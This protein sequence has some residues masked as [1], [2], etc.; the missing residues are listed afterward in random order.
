MFMVRKIIDC[1]L[2]LANYYWLRI[3][4]TIQ[5]VG[6]LPEPQPLHTRMFSRRFIESLVTV[7]Y[8]KVM[9]LGGRFAAFLIL[10]IAL[11][12]SRRQ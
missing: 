11:T 9:V 12:T 3:L 7:M 10:N 1:L 6:K 4:S 5:V 8:L 2:T